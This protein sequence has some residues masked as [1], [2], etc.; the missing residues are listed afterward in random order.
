M[1]WFRSFRPVS[2]SCSGC[3]V[4]WTL[5]EV[6]RAW[7]NEAALFP[8]LFWASFPVCQKRT[9]E[10]FGRCCEMECVLCSVYD[11]FRVVLR[12]K[13]TELWKWASSEPQMITGDTMFHLLCRTEALDVAGKLAVVRDLKS[14]YRNPLVPNYRNE[15]CIQLA[16]ES[17][18]KGNSGVRMLAAAPLGDGLVRASFRDA[19]AG[20]AAGL[21]SGEKAVPKETRWSESRHSTFAGQVREPRRVHLRA[22][23]AVRRKQQR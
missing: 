10:R 2:G 14:R 17:E 23:Q 21:L 11:A 4:V 3:L 6:S 18:L 12:S 22:Q 8:L 1:P 19:S 20:A 5:W 13:S 16:E 7:L 15:L 9:A